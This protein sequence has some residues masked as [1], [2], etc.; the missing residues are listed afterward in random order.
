MKND[1]DNSLCTLLDYT[2]TYILMNDTRIMN[3]SYIII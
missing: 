1:N 3:T 2:L